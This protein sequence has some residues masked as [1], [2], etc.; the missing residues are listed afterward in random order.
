MS[1]EGTGETVSD[2]DNYVSRDE[3]RANPVNEEN[4]PEYIDENLFDYYDTIVIH[5]SDGRTDEDIVDLQD[6]FQNDR[7][8]ADIGY[9]FVINGDGT[10]YEGRPCC[11]SNSC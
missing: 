9:H 1:F 11:I 10:I 2:M 6:Y 7:G 8:Y 5:H 4:D 3:W